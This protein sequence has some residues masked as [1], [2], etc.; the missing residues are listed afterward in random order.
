M[1]YSEYYK[2]FTL[3]MEAVCCPEIVVTDYEPILYRNPTVRSILDRGCVQPRRSVDYVYF[4]A[5]CI[6]LYL[7]SHIPAD[8]VT[9][10]AP[11]AG[12]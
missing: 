5:Y 12:D 9:I 10:P 1:A 2:N 6:S 8:V 7:T 3:K 4:L 11:Y